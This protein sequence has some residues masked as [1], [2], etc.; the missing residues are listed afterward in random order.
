VFSTRIAYVVKSTNRYELKVADADGS[1]PRTALARANR[2]FRRPGRRTA[3]LAYVSFEA[4]KPVIYVHSLAS[5]ARHVA[6]NFK[7]SNSAPAWSPG[8]QEAGGRADQGRQFADLHGQCRRQRLTRIA[9]VLGIDTEPQFSP[10]GQ[11]I[12]F[13]SDRGGSPQI[14]RVPATGGNAERVTFEGSYNVTPRCRRTARA[15]PT[16]PATAAASSSR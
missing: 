3:A 2:S 7:G 1:N 9:T 6:A 8:R 5:G 11:H 12:Y 14:Y 13:T 15:W 10:D 4:K 16:C